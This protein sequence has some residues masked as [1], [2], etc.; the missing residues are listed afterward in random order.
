MRCAYFHRRRLKFSVFGVL[1]AI[2]LS[3]F[4][5]YINGHGWME[6]WFNFQRIYFAAS[7]QWNMC[8]VCMAAMWIDVNLWIGYDFSGPTLNK[9]KMKNMVRL[10]SGPC[11]TNI[12]L[13]PPS[14]EIMLKKKS[15]WSSTTAQPWGPWEKRNFCDFRLFLLTF[16]RATIF[17]LAFF[18]STSVK[19][20]TLIYI[21]NIYFSISIWSKKYLKKISN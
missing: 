7:I 14:F 1:A 3:P 11:S 16:F 20:F 8:T 2:Y 15:R 12:Y 4:L 17:F 21:A 19:A 10:R 13:W 9:K 5:G 6:S 18:V